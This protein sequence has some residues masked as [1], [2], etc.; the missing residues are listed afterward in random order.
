MV[1]PVASLVAGMVVEVADI[2]A[3]NSVDN[4]GD[5]RCPN[6]GSWAD[7][8]QF[9]GSRSPGLM[10]R[11]KDWG[12]LG[13]QYIPVP[14]AMESPSPCSHH[15]ACWDW[16]KVGRVTYFECR[17]PGLVGGAAKACR[18]KARVGALQGF[19]EPGRILP[20]KYVT[21]DALTL[22]FFA[23]GPEP[24]FRYELVAQSG[25]TEKQIEGA[26]R[27]GV[28]S[29]RMLRVR[30]ESLPIAGVAWKYALSWVGL[31]YLELRYGVLMDHHVDL[32]PASE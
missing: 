23:L 21:R 19:L 32:Q 3:N 22:A 15:P 31:A 16:W 10:C 2:T 14:A 6:C 4:P 7:S 5:A 25:L 26:L 13:N 9:R 17:Y 24:H 18:R 12:Y 8:V 27:R 20:G 29:K 11:E 1:S 30:R 28:R